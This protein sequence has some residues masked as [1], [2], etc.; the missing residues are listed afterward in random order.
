MR[1]EPVLTGLVLIVLGLGLYALRNAHIDEA[2]GFVALGGA[3]LAAY[4]YRRQYGF[5][6][7]GG[8]LLGL[9]LGLMG[10]GPLQPLVDEPVPFGL[11]LG[12]LLVW[13]LDRAY[14]RAGSWWPL[15]PGGVLVL[16]GVAEDSGSVEWFLEQGWPLAVVAVGVI[17]VIGGLLGRGGGGS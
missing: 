17:L 4:F 12:F 8:I 6:V 9:G 16:V 13:A 10:F 11:G 1:K 5:L 15:V 2:V 3:F 14:T 7:P